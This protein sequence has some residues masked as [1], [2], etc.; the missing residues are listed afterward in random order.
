MR[1]FR[2]VGILGALVALA[3]VPSA[4]RAQGAKKA[5]IAVLPFE[6]A[7][8]VKTDQSLETEVLVDAFKRVLVQSRKFEVVDRSKLERVRR[9]Q[10]FGQSGLVK[11]RRP[12][13]DFKGAQ[14]LVVGT[15]QDYSAGE[16]RELPYGSGFARP[17]R[18][19]VEVEVVDSS[20][21]QVLAARK[22]VG[23][24][25]AR[26]SSAAEAGR[27]PREGLEQAGE[28]CA[29][30]ALL[31]ILDAAYPIKVIGGSGDS[32]QLNRGEGGGLQAGALL[33]CFAAG[34]ALKDPDTGEVLGASESEVGSVRVTEVLAK[35][36]N[37]QVLDG[38]PREGDSCRLTEDAA[39]E[40]EAGTHRAPP[41]AGPIQSY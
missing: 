41:P 39:G 23:T 24:A 10:R 5:T 21:G 16:V 26:V 12:A 3:A 19:S 27:V 31:A 17:V 36:S 6:L 32:R 18:V 13:T 34:K 22:A 37:A 38:N 9:E 29:N 4:V 7:E 30:D 35:Y 20:T 8:I 1:A 28:Q 33:R 2:N 25:Q 14:Y 40:D 15:V 11:S